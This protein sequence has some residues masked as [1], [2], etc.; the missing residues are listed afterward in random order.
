[1]FYAGDGDCDGLVGQP[2]DI[3]SDTIVAVISLSDY[4]LVFPTAI[5]PNGDGFNDALIF[6]ATPADRSGL[7]WVGSHP[8]A[9]LT[10]FDRWGTLIY[11][12]KGYRNDWDGGSAPN[13][14]Y[15]YILDEGNGNPIHR[16]TL[17]LTR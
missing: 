17:T 4:G 15:Y 2:S 3:F 6:G 12:Q 9:E 1:V 10:V 13:G 7:G 11:T 16:V 8:Q 14:V 5:T